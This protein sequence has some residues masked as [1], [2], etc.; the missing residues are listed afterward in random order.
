MKKS[1]I[2]LIVAFA[3]LA[4]FF[5][6]FQ[7]TFHTY[8]KKGEAS[9]SG[10]YVSEERTLVPFTKLKVSS[11]VMV[12][13]TQDTLTQLKVGAPKNLLDSLKIH[14][15][16]DELTITMGKASIGNDSILLYIHNNQLHTLEIGSEA[17]FEA[18]NTLTGK[19]LQLHMQD[20]STAKLNLSYHSIHCRIAP[21]AEVAFKGTLK[22]IDFSNL[23]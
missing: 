19:A 23:E 11:E 13:Y 18:T 22:N 1:N 3:V 9:G 16:N 20:E 15:E 14:I 4:L 12:R 6:A 8:V 21:D 2:I 7:L 17:Y 5:L 10:A